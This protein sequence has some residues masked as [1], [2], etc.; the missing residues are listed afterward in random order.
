V[1]KR[2]K[3]KKRSKIGLAPCGGQKEKNGNKI[4]GS[5]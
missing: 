4:N 2:V 5:S 1:K 3:K